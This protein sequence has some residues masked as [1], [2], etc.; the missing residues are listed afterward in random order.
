MNRLT[1]PTEVED[2]RRRIAELLDAGGEWFLREGRDGVAVELRRGE[3]ELRVASGALLLSYWGEAGARIWRVAAWE[4]SGARLALEAA[5]RTGAV[6]ARLELV[7]R[8]R[9][10][11]AREAVASARRAVCER[12]AALVVS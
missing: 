1:N 5:R 3:W 4:L 7:P 6:R 12:L 2:A 8:A 10:A 11:S 9:A